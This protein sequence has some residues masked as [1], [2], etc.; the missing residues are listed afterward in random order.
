M[1]WRIIVECSVVHHICPHAEGHSLGIC[2]LKG[3]DGML[4]SMMAAWKGSAIVWQGLPRI[5]S[6]LLVGAIARIVAGVVVLGVD[7]ALVR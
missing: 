7:T 4:F 5:A 1:Y 6:I 2:P 3:K